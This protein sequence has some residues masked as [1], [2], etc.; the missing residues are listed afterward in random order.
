MNG[1]IDAAVQQGLV[2]F[3][4]EQSLAAGVNQW[5]V[6]DSVPGRDDGHDLE[7]TIGMGLL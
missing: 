5:A 1:E 4:G 7:R 2:E 6:L 3:L